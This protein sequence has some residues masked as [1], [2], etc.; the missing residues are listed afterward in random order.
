MAIRR[1]NSVVAALSVGFLPFAL[2]QPAAAEP[3]TPVAYPPGA[4]ATR[5]AGPAFDTCTAPALAKI[6]AWRASPYRAVGIYIG[7]INRSCRQPALTAGWVNRVSRL[8]WRLLPIYVGRQAPCVFHR[9]VA[10]IT[11]SR[12]AAQGQSEARDAVRRARALGLLAGSAIYADIEHYSWTNSACRRAVLR[13]ISGWTRELHRH[14][15]LAGV[16]VHLYSGAKHLS[17]AFT[18]TAFARPDAIWIAR[19]D[20]SA[21]L[22]GWAGI[23]DARWAV[24][25]R[26]KQY[27]G[28]HA[29]RFG[30]V[31]IRIDSNRLDAPVATVAHGYRVTSSGSLNA[32]SGPKGYY[33]VVRRYP[34]G[35]VVRV[36]C[37]TRGSTVGSSKVWNRLVDGTYV[38]DYYVS[39]P[40]NTGF[41]APLPRCSN[42]YQ[43]TAAGVLYQRRG[44]GTSHAVVGALPTGSLAWIVCQRAGTRIGT[45]R[46][47]NLLANG[48]WVADYYV[49]TPSNTTHSRPI[50]RC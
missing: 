6:S 33:P 47:W 43:V 39:T 15:Y 29:E 49:A 14:G 18:S 37:Q 42:P 23:P 27:R 10:K 22:T 16:Y 38:S 13:Y 24:H 21:R 40:S 11:P 26:A 34:R 48:R 30:G 45:S 25:Q 36:M 7:G 35:A 5:Y 44:P 20:N 28:G 50:P 12:A 8:R 17:D 4:A 41:S 9:N 2:A 32:R 46:V 19:W 31:A 3:A 1:A